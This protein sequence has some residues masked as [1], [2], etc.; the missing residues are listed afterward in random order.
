MSITYSDII[1]YLEAI[2]NTATNDAGQAVHQYWWHINHDQ[3]Q[4]ALAYNDFKTGTVY[5]IGVPII[6]IDSKQTDP[7]KSAFYLVL[8]GA[9]Q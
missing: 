6:G 5:G 1:M 9:G 7:L 3:T 4:P 2:A 8:L